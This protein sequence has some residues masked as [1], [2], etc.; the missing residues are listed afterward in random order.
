MKLG[1]I[2]SIFGRPGMMCTAVLIGFSLMI[3]S[4]S[5]ATV[6]GVIGQGPVE[7]PST[8]MPSM[9]FSSSSVAGGAKLVLKK[10][11]VTKRSTLSCTPASYAFLTFLSRSVS[12]QIWGRR[13]GSEGGDGGESGWETHGLL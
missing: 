3:W 9:F 6:L 13:A 10:P 12:S 1:T 11:R 5:A 7:G 2:V 8:S 4:R